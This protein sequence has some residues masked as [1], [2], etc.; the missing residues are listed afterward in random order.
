MITRISIVGVLLLLSAAVIVK[1]SRIEDVPPREPFSQFPFQIASWRGLDTERFSDEVM[2]VLGADDY[3]SRFYRDQ[4]ATVGLYV[5]YYKSQRQGDT[6]HSPLNCLPGAGWQPLGKSYLPIQVTDAS[7]RQSEIT[8]NRYVIEKGLE[9]QVVLYWYQS[10]SRVIAN[11]YRSKIFMVYDAARLNRSDAALV[12]VT[13]P[14]LRSDANGNDAEARA[15]E[16]VK[17][18]FPLLGNFLPS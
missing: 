11:E 13:S 5:G 16:F 9:Q 2:K 8:V 6:M 17:A 1:A 4:R 14:R 10:H 18:L 7:G 3:L 12:R 15:V